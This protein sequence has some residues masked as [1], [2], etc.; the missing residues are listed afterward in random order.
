M[1]SHA[2][3]CAKHPNDGAAGVETRER[4]GHG[5]LFSAQVLRSHVRAVCYRN[6]SWDSLMGD[7][8]AARE[9]TIL[10]VLF[11]V[12]QVPARGGVLGC[13]SSLLQSP[14]YV[15]SVLDQRIALFP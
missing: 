14:F 8:I 9:T 13:S 5:L 7:S 1:S 3:K 2:I 10:G 15:P 11:E 12:L 4:L 6:L